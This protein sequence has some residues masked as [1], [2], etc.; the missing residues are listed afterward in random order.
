M[1][2]TFL[3]LLY[4]L[5]SSMLAEV[6]YLIHKPVKCSRTIPIVVNDVCARE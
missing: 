5:L 6:F 1:F 3:F 4:I 2:F